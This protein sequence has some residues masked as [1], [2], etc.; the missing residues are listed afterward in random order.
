M[1]LPHDLDGGGGVGDWRRELGEQRFMAYIEALANLHAQTT[2]LTLALS[3]V[4]M[5]GYSDE[6]IAHAEGDIK[7]MERGARN[8]ATVSR[9]MLDEWK[10][11]RRRMERQR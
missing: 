7:D 11:Q 1:T 8:L 10:Q 5:A 9:Q 3:A 2:F 6:A 4:A